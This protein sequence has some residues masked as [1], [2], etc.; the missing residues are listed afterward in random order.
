MNC[1]KCEKPVKSKSDCVVA[2]DYS[3]YFF[4]LP[5]QLK[6]YHK[7]CFNEYRKSSSPIAT[8]D[9]NQLKN[10]KNISFKL[11]IFW[12]VISIIPLV[13]FI[14]LF[15]QGSKSD[16]IFVVLLLSIFPSFLTYLYKSRLKKIK[17][18]EKLPST[19]K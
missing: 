12:I 11:M 3:W 5:P 16:E 18:I 17:E 4:K 8:V 19:K 15:V 6:T 1:A 13:L 9:S 10:L 14:T 2:Y 7:N